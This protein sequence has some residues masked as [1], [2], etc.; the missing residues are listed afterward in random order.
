[1]DETKPTLSVEARTR[2]IAC[3]NAADTARTL[4]LKSGSIEAFT[5]RNEIIW[6]WSNE[7]GDKDFIVPQPIY[8]V[9][10]FH[11]ERTIPGVTRMITLFQRNG[12]ELLNIVLTPIIID[13][14]SYEDHFDAL[15]ANKEGYLKWLTKESKK[16]R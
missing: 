2:L 8:P 7:F 1:M 6:L 13:E 4:W 16:W 11:A 3:L 14:V 9:N 12:V 10:Q 15:K 5:A